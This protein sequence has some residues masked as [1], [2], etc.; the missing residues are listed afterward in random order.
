MVRD[1]ALT[2][3]TLAS[4]V[5]HLAS[6]ADDGA[7]FTAGFRPGLE[8]RRGVPAWPQPH[9][10]GRIRRLGALMGGSRHSQNRMTCPGIFG[11][12]EI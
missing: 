11:P 5:E 9:E 6:R 7:S 8:R 4:R 3:G 10:L 12:A 1:A 2:P